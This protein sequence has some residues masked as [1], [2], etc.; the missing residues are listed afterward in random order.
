ML[1]IEYNPFKVTGTVFFLRIKFDDFD[2]RHLI[3]YSRFE[4][5]T[6]FVQQVSFQAIRQICKCQSCRW[7]TDP[8]YNAMPIA[9]HSLAKFRQYLSQG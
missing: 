4:T 7:Q 1:A 5:K 2:A 9:L 6:F 3:V 8:I